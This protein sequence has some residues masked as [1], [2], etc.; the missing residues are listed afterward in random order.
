LSSVVVS[1]GQIFPKSSIFQD[2][3]GRIYADITRRSHRLRRSGK[4]EDHMRR[5][6]VGM[7]HARYGTF[8][9]LKR[10]GCAGKVESGSD[11]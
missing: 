4:F 2:V 7:E 5:G 9:I 3:I 11:E 1:L 6:S 8:K 10:P